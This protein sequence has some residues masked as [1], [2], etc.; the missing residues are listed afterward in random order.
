[1]KIPGIVIF[2]HLLILAGLVYLHPPQPK[3][4]RPVTVQTYVLQEEKPKTIV[5]APKPQPEPK[6]FVEAKPKI[7][8]K[9]AAK[10][11]QQ[12]IK[13]SDPNRDKLIQMMQQSLA[14]LDN[15][16]TSSSKATS[17]K[18]IGTLASEALTFESSYQNQLIAFLKK[19]LTLPERGDVK[20]SLT[21]NRSGGVKAITVKE[22]ASERNRAYVESTVHTLFLPPFANNFKGESA[23]TF[24]IILTS[25]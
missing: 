6:K 19:A 5:E 3:P 13:Q 9:P 20:L 7:K 8:S 23:H 14:S 25:S 24:P 16:P 4:K 11:S 12:G 17:T 2:A 22:S 15:S 18:Q 1:M 21:L 10:P